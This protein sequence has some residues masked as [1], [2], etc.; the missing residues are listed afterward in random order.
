MVPKD[1]L[2]AAMIAA[3]PLRERGVDILLLADQLLGRASAI[4]VAPYDPRRFAP[5]ILPHA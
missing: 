4:P 5:G 3:P 2:K 1:A